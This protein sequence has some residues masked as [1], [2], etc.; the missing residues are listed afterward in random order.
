MNEHWTIKT[1][2]KNMVTFTRK[3]N[4]QPIESYAPVTKDMASVFAVAIIQGF[5]PPRNLVRL[6][7]L[8]D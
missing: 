2:N 4:E 8:V 5:E 3:I 7:T 1:D 6:D